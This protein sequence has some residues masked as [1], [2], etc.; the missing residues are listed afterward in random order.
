M[1]S[2]CYIGIGGAAFFFFFDFVRNEIIEVNPRA[3]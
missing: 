3:C 1:C 2:N